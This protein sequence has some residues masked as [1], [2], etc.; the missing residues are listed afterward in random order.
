MSLEPLSA[1]AKAAVSAAIKPTLGFL[2]QQIARRGSPFADL[3]S[4][5]GADK[6]LDEAI[7]VLKGSASSLPQTLL[8]KLKGI[9]SD[10]PDSFT[11]AEARQFIAEERAVDLIK[12]GARRTLGGEEIDAERASARLLHAELFGEDGI[13]GE[14]LIEDAIAFASLTLLAHLSPSDR[15]LLELLVNV[16]DEMRDGFTEILGEIRSLNFDKGMASLD[17]APFDDVVKAGTWKLRRQRMLPD[18]GVVDRGLAFGRRVETSLHLASNEARGEAFR[19]VAVLLIRATRVEDAEEWLGKAEA[20]GAD[21]V[22]ERARIAVSEEKYDVALKLLRDRDDAASRG[23]VMDTIG[24]RDSDEASLEHF[25]SQMKITDLTGPAVQ[26]VAVRMMIAGRKE[27]ASALIDQASDAQIAENP[28]LLF[29]R[30]RLSISEAVPP[31]IGE[32]ILAHDGMVPRPTDFRDD[33]EGRRHREA[34]RAY[35]ER[36]QPALQDLE[37]PGFSTLIDINLIVLSLSSP[38]EAI[39]ALA[40]NDFV[41]RMKDPAQDVVLAPLAKMYDIDVDWNAL[42]ERLARA[43]MLGGYDDDQLRAAFTIIME[44]GT[45]VE[46]AAFVHR[47]RDR[48]ENY[49]IN[50]SVVAIEIEALAKSGRK[51]DALALLGA[52]RGKLGEAMAGFLESTIAELEGADT[53]QARLGQF[54]TTGSTHDLEILVNTMGY[55]RDPRLGTYLVKLWRLRR[56]LED[57]QRACEMLISVGEELQAEDFL[58]ELGDEARADPMLRTHLAWARYRQGR[59]AEA[60]EELTELGASGADNDNTRRLAVLLAIETGQWTNLEP[61][62]RHELASKVDRSAVDLVAAARIAG[63][64]GSLA[65]MDLLIAAT[66]TAPEDASI[67]LQAYTIATETGL[68]RAPIVGKW[69]KFALEKKDDVGLIEKTDLNEVI[70]MMTSSRQEAER[71]GGLINSASVPMFMGI[72]ALGGSQSELVIHRMAQ[73]AAENDPRRRSVVPLYAGNRLL[74]FDQRPGSISFDPL[75]I[76]VLSQLGLL[77]KAIDAFEDV[78]LPSG[79]LHSFFEDCGKAKHSQ[80]TRVTQ[81]KRIKDAVANGLLKVID[82]SA[83]DG[84]A[85]IDAEF[86]SLFAQADQHDGYLIDTCP[87][88]PPGRLDTVVDPAPYQRR[89]FTPAGLVAAVRAAGAISRTVANAADKIVVGSG[90]QF[91]HEPALVRGRPLYLTNIAVHYLIDADLLGALKAHAGE[92]YTSSETVLLADREIGGAAAADE[93]RAGIEPVRETLAKAIASGRARV[94][95]ARRMKG[96]LGSEDERRT[97]AIRMN[98]I[99]SVLRDTAGIDAFV[100]DDR[101]M[102]KYQETTDQTGKKVIFLTT[103][104]LLGIMRAK[105]A[106]DNDEVDAARERLRRSGAGMMLADPD[107]LRRYVLDSDWNIGPN[108]ELRAVRDS[109]HLP[110]ARKIVQLPEERPWVRGIVLAI[111]YTIHDTW[112]KIEDDTKAEIAANWLLD[113]L[114]DCAALSE[115]DSS[116]DR[117]N[118]ISEV[119]RMSTWAMSSVFGLSESRVEQYRSWFANRVEPMIDRRD[120][121]AYKI[122]GKLLFAS[123]TNPSEPE[124][125]DD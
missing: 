105:D 15:Q 43:E 55:R 86:A 42:K 65:T 102:N 89:L 5:R 97:S 87:L 53:V 22:P 20:L 26:A 13:Y 31:D 120:P 108:A 35:L 36:L 62:V 25:A 19:E 63:A 116:A 14:T 47:H 59:L 6:E 66:E 107:E 117:Q 45:P 123:M 38:D 114:P 71:I 50:D 82:M 90:E 96:E 83:T 110:L 8:A 79:T 124:V 101:G 46:I 100:C 67:A 54:E 27:E 76:L 77:D 30:A 92:L 11:S 49:S 41:E 84:S 74:R 28:I 98:P 106:V 99:M 78:V 81:A 2:R 32:R 37:S 56:Q 1:T 69:L 73:N 64:I 68:E 88:H 34:A 111:A 24:R 17:S 40:R 80:P 23:L 9:M 94:G 10:R 125:S 122:V 58:D 93:I 3:D 33:V 60:A 72:G 112:V 21:T 115:N 103:A 70:E 113:L 18:A 61:H 7:S 48:L 85:E 57:A 95:P 109:I 29:I 121:G 52:E 91:P 4:L 39:R 44:E 118:W 119:T 16:R 51:E 75:S 104:D 12:T